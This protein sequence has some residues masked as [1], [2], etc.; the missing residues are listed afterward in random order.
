[1]SLPVIPERFARDIVQR[2]GPSAEPWLLRL[3]GVVDEYARRWSLTL[4]EPFSALSF[5][6]VTRANTAE[7]RPVVLKVG[8]PEDKEFRTEGEA[9]RLYGGRG[10]VELVEVEFGDA[11]M[12]L[13]LVEPGVPL[14]AVEDDEEA[15]LIA[16]QLMRRFWRP[17]P[18]NHSFPTVARWALGLE[19]HRERFGGSG[20]I[21]R[22]LFERA[23]ALYRDLGASMA[24]PVLLHGDLHQENVLSATR[25]PWLAIDPK[26]LIGEPAY[27]TG[28]LLRN[29]HEQ[30]RAQPDPKPLL[31]RRIAQMAGELGV[32]RERV[33]GWGVAQAVLSAC[34]FL[35]DG[36]D[37]GPAA[38]EVACASALAELAL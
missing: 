30:L 10:M 6:Y 19:R 9:L 33:R 22:P 20:P 2:R 4:G 16:F 38:L 5:N 13:E 8:F 28:S 21:P 1:M 14:T 17:I 25:E 27:E 11:V 12:L 32:E 36:A 29:P 3:P 15:I 35:E 18:E 26:G 34:W 7:G 37:D 31:A 23:E 24:E